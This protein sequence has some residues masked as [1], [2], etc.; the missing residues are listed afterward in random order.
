MFFSKP[1]LV[2]KFFFPCWS[3]AQEDYGY[4]EERGRLGGRKKRG[5]A[6]DR[7]GGDRERERERENTHEREREFCV[8]WWKGFF[9]MVI[10]LLFFGE[11]HWDNSPSFPTRL[12]WVFLN[13]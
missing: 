8:C 9:W 5:K 1:L 2:I 11:T 7:G 4:E 13:T 12:C 10:S 6:G 3:W